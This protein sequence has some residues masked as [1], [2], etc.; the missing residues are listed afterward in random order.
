MYVLY[1]STTPASKR[2]F[3]VLKDVLQF[4]ELYVRIL[5]ELFVTLVQIV[6]PKKQKDVSGEIVLVRALHVQK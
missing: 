5:L 3:D 2:I 6:L 1:C 4:F